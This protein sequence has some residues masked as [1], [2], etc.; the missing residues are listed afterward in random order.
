MATVYAN[1]DDIVAHLPGVKAEV[2]ATAQ[3]GAARA[4]GILAA[5]RYEGHSRITVTR[6]SLDAFV[7]LDDTRGDHAA[8]AIEYGRSG[9]RGG[10]TQGVHALSRA[11]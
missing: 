3:K 2:Y 7:S 8:A 10:A 1:T 6:G 11:F 5:H 4:E 9:G